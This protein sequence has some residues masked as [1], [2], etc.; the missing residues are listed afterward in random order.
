MAVSAAGSREIVAKPTEF[1]EMLA[2]TAGVVIW[3]IFLFGQGTTAAI[4]TI[5][6][7][8]IALP[9]GGWTLL[10]RLRFAAGI[11]VFTVGPWRRAVDLEALESIRWTRT[12]GGLSRGTISVRDRQGRRAPIYVGRFDRVAEWG[13]LLLEAAR[14]SDAHVDAHSRRL[15]EGAAAPRRARHR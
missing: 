1:G 15:L 12:G 14:R 13:P 9:L 3:F 2:A 6:L 4:E 11:F 5:W 7:L 8:L 10:M